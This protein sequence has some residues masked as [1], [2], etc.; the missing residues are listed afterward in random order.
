MPEEANQH[1]LKIDAPIS[2]D[3]ARRQRNC[4]IS[5]VLLSIAVAVAVY[6]VFPGEP[7]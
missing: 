7:K 5:W 4:L 1:F 2:E 6:T 3:I